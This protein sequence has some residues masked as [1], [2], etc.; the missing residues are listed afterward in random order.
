MGDHAAVGSQ[1][2]TPVVEAARPERPISVPTVRCHD[3]EVCGANRGWHR[4]AHDVPVAP[5][6]YSDTGSAVPHVHVW[7]TPS[8]GPDLATFACTLPGCRTLTEVPLGYGTPEEWAAQQERGD[9]SIAADLAAWNRHQRGCAACTTAP[10]AASLCLAGTVLWQRAGL[11]VI[12]VP[13]RPAPVPPPMPG[14][15]Q[16]RPARL[17]TSELLRW[18]A[19][20]MEQN[21]EDP[22][23]VDL[24]DAVP[25]E[26]RARAAYLETLGDHDHGRVSK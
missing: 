13:A 18:A 3:G 19:L 22:E 8:Y 7:G 14:V 21:P 17:R 26:L 25:S 15:A 4:E 2:G 6:P 24:Y 9:R 11:E 23:H 12:P 16:Q 10:T 20:L 5:G 1:P